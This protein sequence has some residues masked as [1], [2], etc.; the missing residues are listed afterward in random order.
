ME[1]YISIIL[2]ILTFAGVFFIGDRWLKLY[3]KLRSQ[4]ER[5]EI[6]KDAHKQTLP[7]RLQ[8]YE[9]A[10][11]FLERLDFK[12]LVIR[13][14]RN[15]MNAKLMQVEM[16]KAIREEF[17]HNLSQQL[18]LSDGAW[19]LLVFAKEESIRIIQTAGGQVGD[20]ASVMEF[21]AMLFELMRGL[22][23]NPVKEAISLVKKDMK[24]KVEI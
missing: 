8:A 23:S 3:T 17:E 21:S 24:R 12:S 2:V 22:K 7:V 14:N 9:R 19:S 1:P 15:G 5:F 11:I 6:I 4:S 13:L 10:L 18:Y 20:E 16:V